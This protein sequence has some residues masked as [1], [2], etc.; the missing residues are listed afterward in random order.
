M[1]KPLE[2]DD[3]DDVAVAHGL[4]GR[5]FTDSLERCE[6]KWNQ[7]L[8]GERYQDVAL[9]GGLYSYEAPGLPARAL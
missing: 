9:K 2:I 4:P 6:K 1:A 8:A 7:L 5:P 3:D